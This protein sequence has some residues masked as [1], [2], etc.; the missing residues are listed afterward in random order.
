[1]SKTA[2]LFPGQGAQYVGMGKDFYEKYPVSKEVFETACAVSG[3]D[4]KALCFEENENI[5]VT[6]YT[7]IAMLT[8][9]IAILKA[10]EEAGI[11]ADVAAGLSLGE[12]GAIAA[13]GVMEVPDVLRLIRKRG[14]YMQEAVPQGGAMTAVLG[15]DTGVIEKVCEEIREE[16]KGIVSI[17]NYNC[18]G[19]TVITGEEDA[20]AKAAEALAGAGAKRCVPLKVSGP[21][22]SA[23]LT[24]A[25]K[26]LGKELEAVKLYEMKIPYL[27]NVTADYV[28]DLSEVKTLLEQ[29]VASSVR[30]QQSVE[31][32]ITD[33]VDT[34]I[35]IGPG[36]TL[37][38]FMRKIN[39]EVKV[40]NVEKAE[41]LEK[42][43]KEIRG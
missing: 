19:Q 2:F 1:M 25:G 41:D 18:P 35:E 24:E 27:S 37:A 36:K 39:R 38:G 31:R 40:F 11:H 5:H 26:K 9:E 15:L 32:M 30:W 34:F 10:I 3:L 13:A 6:E 12:Y 17:A 7:Q 42:L 14:I 21:F 43:E 20:V 4:V 29:Q 8:A 22:H 23:L 16:T 33:G 28:T